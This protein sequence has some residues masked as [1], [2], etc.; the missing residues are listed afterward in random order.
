MGAKVCAP[1]TNHDTFYRGAAAG[2][3]FADPVGDV[4]L[5]VGGAGLTAGADVVTD[6]GALFLQGF[7]QY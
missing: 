4:E 3:G 5:V 7:L 6:A 2:A 1:A